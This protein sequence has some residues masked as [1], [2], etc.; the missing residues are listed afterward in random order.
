MKKL[1]LTILFL[2]IAYPSWA[3]TK[4]VRLLGGTPNGTG[5]GTCNGTVNV[6]YSGGVSPNC[7]YNSTNWPLPIGGQDTTWQLAAGDTLIIQQGAYKMGR[8]SKADGTQADINITN[9][10]GCSAGASS[11]CVIYPIPSG[12]DSSH[13]TKIYGE[14]YAS[15]TTANDTELW[16]DGNLF[17]IINMYGADNVELKCLEISDHE[18]CGKSGNPALTCTTTEGAQNGIYAFQSENVILD[19]VDIHGLSHDGV[20]AGQNQD[21]TI[22]YSNFNFNG[23]A[24]WDGDLT[25]LGSSEAADAGLMAF[26]HFQISWNGFIERYPSIANT[27]VDHS[28]SEQNNGGYGDGFSPYPGGPLDA[29]PL[30]YRMTDGEISHN[31]SDGLDAL[32]LIGG[33][34]FEITRLKAEGNNGN[35]V[36]LSGIGTMDDSILIGNCG[37]P[38]STMSYSGLN[39]CRAGGSTLSW[40][41]TQPGDTFLINNSTFYGQG[42]VVILTSTYNANVCDGSEVLKIRNSIIQGGADWTAAG[43]ELSN[44]YYATGLVGNDGFGTC[45]ALQWDISEANAGNI[46]YNSKVSPCPATGVSCVNPLFTGSLPDY[47]TQGWYADVSLQAGSPARSLRNAAYGNSTDFNGVTRKNSIGALEFASAPGIEHGLIRGTLL[48]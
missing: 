33:D 15:C 32:H 27:P 35:Q 12:V 4:Y 1:L 39:N 41:I 47:P 44:A 46:V 42:D 28:G 36:K 24:G 37:F 8:G 14:N 13:K 30:T 23:N 3:T 31:T 26:D 18:E 17:Y 29:L 22:S 10:A 19:H 40:S 9:T 34:R 25:G 48:K 7:A 6:D 38:D 16:G 45:T 11:D 20:W 21:W 43:G 2:M 5:L